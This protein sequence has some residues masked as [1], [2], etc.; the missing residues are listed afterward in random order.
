MRAKMAACTTARAMAG[1]S[2]AL[3]ASSGLPPLDCVQPGKPPA[4]NHCSFTEN[5]RISKMA[6][7]KLGMAMPICARAITPTSPQRL[8]RD[9]AYTPASS[10]STAVMSMASS[11][12]GMVSAN[13]SST[14]SST[15]VL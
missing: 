4:E 6:N 13:R 5:S 1:S 7:Q 10:A 11:A 14:R 9:A 8:W 12:S 15:G 2:R 3:S